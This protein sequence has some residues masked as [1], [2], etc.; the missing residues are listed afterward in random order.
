MAGVIA[1]LTTD[2][3]SFPVAI[4]AAIGVGAGFIAGRALG[5]LSRLGEVVHTTR[6]PGLLTILDGPV[7]AAAS[8]WAA[9]VVFG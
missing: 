6:A 7:L 8:F 4:L 9:V 2:V 3:L 1:A 5:S